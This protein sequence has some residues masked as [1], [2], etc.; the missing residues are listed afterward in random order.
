MLAER[1]HGARLRA[2]RTFGM[3]CDEAHL[4]ADREL[5]EPASGNAVAVKIDLVTVGAQDKTTILPGE[6]PG[7]PPVVGHGM[8]FDIPPRLASV[9]FEQPTRCVESIADRD[10]HILMRMMRRGITADGDLAPR[11]PQVD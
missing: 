8:Q 9:V 10:V 5:V 6:E 2:L 4:V 1:H 7:D 3:L 11:D